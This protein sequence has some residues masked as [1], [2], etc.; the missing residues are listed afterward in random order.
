M[1]QDHA[2]DALLQQHDVEVDQET[3][4]AAGMLQVREQLRIM[5]SVE[6]RDRFQFDDHPPLDQ[7]VD[8]VR[9][10]YAKLLVLNREGGLPKE[11]DSAAMKFVSE[12][13][14]IG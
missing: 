4:R 6:R 11:S 7:E 2:V 10:G 3:R 8:T 5:D 13:S 14:L 9:G 1:V 12:T